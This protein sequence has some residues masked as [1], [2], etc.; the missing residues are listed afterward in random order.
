VVEEGF[1]P[2]APSAPPAGVVK[3]RAGAIERRG[4]KEPL[5]HPHIIESA[6]QLHH[7]TSTPVG[8]EGVV[9]QQFVH[10]LQPRVAPL[11]S[12]PPP[13]DTNHVIWV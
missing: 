9:G 3:E 4:R 6:T 5:L 10:P 1:L 12:A 11:K 7:N 2:T 8:G 13:L